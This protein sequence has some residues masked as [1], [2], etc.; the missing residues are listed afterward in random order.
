MGRNKEPAILRLI[1]K[2]E[3]T[4]YCWNWKGFIS[5]N[6]YGWFWMNNTGT[7]AHKASF[8]LFNREFIGSKYILHKCDNRKCVNPEHLFLGTQSDNIKDC[9]KKRRHIN[10]NKT[11]CIR[12]HLYNK[13][14]TR[15]KKSGWRDCRICHN[16]RRINEN[17][18]RSIIKGEL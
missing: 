5:P 4:S 13:A 17:T 14:N 11:H 12:G 2:I 6:G 3:F 1:R 16:L 8:I 18:I 9:V 10:S 7:S 15:I